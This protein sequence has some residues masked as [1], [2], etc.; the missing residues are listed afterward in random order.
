[1]EEI[2]SVAMAV[3]NMY[4]ALGPGLAAYWGTGG[5]HFGQKP[6]LGFG[7]R[8]HVDGILLCGQTGTDRWPVGKRRP[9]GEKVEWVG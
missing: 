9:V 5:L 8:G 3:Q 7:R 6:S 4:L 2:A 1:M